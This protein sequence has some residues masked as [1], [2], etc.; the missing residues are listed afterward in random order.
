MGTV[1]R[2]LRVG[3]IGAYIN[4]S[5]NQAAIGV[6]SMNTIYRNAGRIDAT[7]ARRIRKSAICVLGASANV[8]DLI[9]ADGRGIELVKLPAG[10]YQLRVAVVDAAQV[11]A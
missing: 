11:T 6:D 2:G 5:R 9:D 4:A 7:E 1:W 10:D 3:T 8:T